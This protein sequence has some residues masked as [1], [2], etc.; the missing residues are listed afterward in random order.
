MAGDASYY[1]AGGTAGSDT[2]SNAR[3]GN[4]PSSSYGAGGGGGGGDFSNNKLDSTGYRGEGGYASTRITGTETVVSG[5]TI[6]ITIGGAGAGTSSGSHSGGNGAAGFAKITVDGVA[7][8]FTS[9][10][11]MTLTS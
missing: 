10:G 7:T 6:S 4:A 9:S 5:T 8:N 3:G 1:G 2:A 11:T